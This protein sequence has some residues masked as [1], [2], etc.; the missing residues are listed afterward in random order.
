M[1]PLLFG[2]HVRVMLLT[3]LSLFLYFV[4]VATFG[5]LIASGLESSRFCS[6]STASD[7]QRGAEIFCPGLR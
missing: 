7:R 5:F 2:F 4:V 1:V 3:D 6:S